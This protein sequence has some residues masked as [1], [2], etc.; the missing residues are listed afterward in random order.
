[1][2][3]DV[4]PI[5]EIRLRYHAW[6]SWPREMRQK[7]HGL[8]VVFSNSYQR[9]SKYWFYSGQPTYSLNHYTERKNNYN[10]WPLEDS[11]LG[12][13]V[14]Y[15]D[16]YGLWR[17]KD[18]LKTPIGW[19]GY[20]YDSV[21]ISFAKVKIAVVPEK[22]SIKKNTGF[23]L[24]CTFNFPKQYADYISSHPN[25]EDTTRIGIFNS[26]GWIKDIFTPISLKD[27][28]V[29]KEIQFTIHPGLPAGKYFMRFA[30]NS[31]YRNPTHNSDKIELRID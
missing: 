28:I 16:K 13:P 23:R 1:M 12:K 4:L 21:F 31:G 29:K 18:S 24:A 5:K 17:F 30:I 7:T 6:K 15:L 11:L 27:M 8:P 26:G 22:I 19:V 20:L 14:Y 3:A 2:I 9:A 10:F 25:L